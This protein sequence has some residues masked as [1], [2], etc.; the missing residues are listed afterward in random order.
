[1]NN[2]SDLNLPKLTYSNQS[3]LEVTDFFN[4]YT[5]DVYPVIE[6]LVTNG[7]QTVFILHQNIIELLSLCGALTHFKNLTPQQKNKL[8]SRYDWSKG[9]IQKIER[10]MT[11]VTNKPIKTVK[12][13]KDAIDLKKVLN[14]REL[15]AL[16]ARMGTGKTQLVGVP[17]ADMC[18]SMGVTPIFIAH[19]TSLISEINGRSSTVNYE[20]TKDN[21]T[22]IK[23]AK[24]EGLSV[25]LNSIIFENIQS[26]INSTNGNYSLFIDECA[27][28][29]NALADSTMS[30]SRKVHAALVDL[31]EKSKSVIFADA[32]MNNNAVNFIEN[33][34]KRKSTVIFCDK[35]KSDINVNIALQ[36]GNDNDQTGRLMGAAIDRLKSGKKVA[37]IS[38]RARVAKAFNDEVMKINDSGD[39][40]INSVL[41]AGDKLQNEQGENFKAN[42][43]SLSTHY[44]SIAITPTITSGISI[45]NTDFTH[46]YCDF[47]C[48]SISH[49]DALQQSSRFRS[50]KVFYVALSTRGMNR[51]NT[52][53][54]LQYWGE[55]LKDIYSV[56]E[57]NPLDSTNLL[58]EKIKKN[59]I[60]SQKHFAQFM[61]SRWI[62]LGYQVNVSN[63]SNQIDCYDVKTLISDIKKEEMINILMAELISNTQLWEL[64][65]KEITTEQEKHQIIHRELR[66]LINMP[67][68]ERFSEWHLDHTYMGYGIGAIR[69]NSILNGDIDADF[70]ESKEIE[71][72]LTYDK[73]RMPVLTQK[74]GRKIL[75]LIFGCTPTMQEFCS[76]SLA[77]EPK[78]T[79][80]KS[81]LKPF[82]EWLENNMKI[83]TI[84]GL[85]SNKYLFEKWN[86]GKSETPIITVKPIVERGYTEVAK[87]ALLRMGLTFKAFD[88]NRTKDPRTNKP[89]NEHIY[90]I[91]FNDTYEMTKIGEWQKKK[92]T[93][94]LK[95]IK[96]REEALKQNRL[97]NSQMK[98]EELTEEE[99]KTLDIFVKG[100]LADWDF[101]N[102]TMSL[103][104]LK[105]FT[106]SNQYICSCCGSHEMDYTN[107]FNINTVDK[108]KL[109][110]QIFEAMKHQ[111]ITA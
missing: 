28:T 35:D 54:S 105:C 31:I 70:L 89:K 38:N 55:E 30:E 107:N 2:Q 92:T 18:R 43:E 33:A 88:R 61:V 74:L 50:A 86:K 87:E 20:H 75:H 44:H 58:L 63:F 93:E 71:K 57:L 46:I 23:R 78:Y 26:I 56:D 3:I 90:R 16:T 73:R 29:I 11:T 10:S 60:L 22:Q 81:T 39:Y 101:F 36:H 4:E 84:L 82:I 62:D 24:K 34:A 109:R 103:Y 98:Y 52:E 53:L 76:D 69:R 80:S 1:M 32:D 97:S 17:F 19:R 65:K 25:C 67:D 106:P 59:K 7:M 83:C 12:T 96:E 111:V 40:S 72:N 8:I 102:A 95:A 6:K 79:F 13:L 41:V 47:D 99:N 14:N 91:D 51:A 110:Y 48:S 68:S 66:N 94:I 49:F 42:A 100:T 45:D 9:I 108:D 104:C 77:D 37:F 27:Q 5:G 15:I 21:P 85:S 64:Q